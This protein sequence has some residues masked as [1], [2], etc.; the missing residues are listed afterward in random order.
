MGAILYSFRRCPY[1]MRAR[2]ALRIAKIDYEHREVILR[3]KP[4]AMLDVS[5]KGTVPVLLFE[6]G[7]VL[8]ESI[9][10]MDY[11]LA[12]HVPLNW[13]DEDTVSGQLIAANDG[14][15]KYHLD[16]YKYASRYKDDAK[17]GD[18]DLSH[19]REAERHI[20]TLEALL[21][22]NTYLLS[23]YQSLADIAIFP[24]I[25]QFANTDKEWWE[26]NPYAKTR[27]WLSRQINSDLFQN[28]MTKHPVWAEA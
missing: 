18:I 28:I 24:F 3:D 21:S 15:F 5:P 11:A 17:R 22:D 6:D 25:R 1:A 4:Q 27:E 16:H 8:D 12:C 20:Q 10:I 19:R 26:A 14:P 9:D 23:D 13:R 7:R 2:M